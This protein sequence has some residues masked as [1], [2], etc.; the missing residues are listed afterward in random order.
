MKKTCNSVNNIV[1]IS[2]SFLDSKSILNKGMK[3]KSN[4]I[5]ILNNHVISKCCINSDFPTISNCFVAACPVIAWRCCLSLS[6]W[7]Q[8]IK[9][10]E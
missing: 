7:R 8:E 5:N 1:L 2:I 9:Y 3:K 4:F 6:G 10:L